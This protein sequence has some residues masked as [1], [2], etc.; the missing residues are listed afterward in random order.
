MGLLSK[1]GSLRSA[2]IGSAADALKVGV[3]CVKSTRKFAAFT[4]VDEKATIIADANK[5]DPILFIAIP[6]QLNVP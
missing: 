1:Y 3:V 2:F 4:T 5:F 6:S